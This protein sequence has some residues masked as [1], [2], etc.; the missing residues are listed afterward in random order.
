METLESLPRKSLAQD[1]YSE[2]L[3]ETENVLKEALGKND[4][5]T[6]KGK[7]N[8]AEN[9]KT[10]ESTASKKRLSKKFRFPRLPKSKSSQSAKFS[11]VKPRY[12]DVFK[13]TSTTV[14]PVKPISEIN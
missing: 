12:L 9:S 5:L 3:S 13:N 8:V 10:I 1:K 14:K 4:S 6:A 7:S 11:H 2:S